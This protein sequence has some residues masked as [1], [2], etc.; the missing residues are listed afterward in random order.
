LQVSHSSS[1]LGNAGVS[2]GQ[3]PL[4]L[5]ASQAAVCAAAVVQA[6]FMGDARTAVAVLGAGIDR[7]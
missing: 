7:E 5:V 6:R 2:A 3:Q 1:W 4:T